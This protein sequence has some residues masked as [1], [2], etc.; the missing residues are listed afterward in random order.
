MNDK[1]QIWWDVDGD[2]S[3]VTRVVE[4]VDCD[5]DGDGVVASVDDVV[6]GKC[7]D[8]SPGAVRRLLG[9]WIVL[10]TKKN[11]LEEDPR[12]EP[13][14]PPSD[15]Q[16]PS[17]MLQ[18]N[19]DLQHE[20]VVV[21][22]SGGTASCMYCITYESIFSGTCALSRCLR[23][24]AT[25]RRIKLIRGDEEGVGVVL[26]VDGDDVGVTLGAATVTNG[27]CSSG[28]VAITTESCRKGE[29]HIRPIAVGT[30]WRRLV[31]KISSVLIGHSLDGYFDDLQ[32]G[33]GVSGGGEAI[34][35][36]VNHLIE[37]RGDDVGNTPYGHAKGCSKASYLDDGT[38][39]GDTLVVGKEDPRSKLAGVFPPIIAR[40]LHGVK[41]LGRPASVDFNFSSELV[42]KRVAKIIVLM[43]T[44]AKINDLQCE[45]L[46]C[47][48]CTGISKLY[49]AMRTCSPQV[50]EMAEHFFD[51]AHR[52]ALERIVTASGHGMLACRL[53]CFDNLTNLPRSLLPNTAALLDRLLYFACRTSD[54][55][56]SSF[57]HTE[58]DLTNQAAVKTF[59]LLKSRVILAAAKVGGIH[60]N[61][62]YH[63]DFITVNLQTQT[64]VID[65]AYR[66]GVKKLI[67][68]GSCIYP[69]HAPQ[70]IRES[71]LLTG[72]LEPTNEWYAVAKIDGIKMCQAYTI[73]YKWDAISAMPTNLNGPNDNF[74]PKNSHV[75]SAL[76]RRFHEAS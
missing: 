72:P 49:F 69:K 20:V 1:H 68:L 8:D 29:F 56:T 23:E 42:M 34:L 64:N 45:L 61:S 14:D 36:T 63:A 37:G 58:L 51:A 33:V 53:S 41:L 9:P 47:R 59:F 44:F 71:A 54:T 39:I 19:L 75:L 48:A 15:G 38:I 26:I 28:L 65:Y 22:S 12:P 21:A 17:L 27:T 6:N 62:T 7:P 25:I 46:L 18:T 31:S 43:D 73:Q 30:V 66:Y 40:P 50:F 60:A 57:V 74:H 10:P 11:W 3:K 67:F 32:F 2:E 70:P 5:G 35:H 24:F 52:Y 16:S 4:G 76:I 13:R 55:P